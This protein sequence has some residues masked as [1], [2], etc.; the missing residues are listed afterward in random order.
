MSPF[1]YFG[2]DK[3]RAKRLFVAI[4]G[5][6]LLAAGSSMAGTSDD[7][8]NITAEVSPYCEIQ[9]PIQDVNIDYNPYDSVNQT[10]GTID[11]ACVRGTNFTITAISGNNP[12][13][14]VGIMRM[15]GEDD[16]VY[17]ITY[18]LSATVNYGGGVSAATFNL[19]SAPISLTAPSIDPPTAFH[20]SMAFGGQ[21]VPVGTYSDTVTINI[22]Y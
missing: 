20:V 16:V 21:P 17:E 14:D 3:M 8:V 2:G 4:A 11:F 7:S 5:L 12:G 6:S 19:F 1:L 15:T 18:R 13:G 22:T 9:N 10:V